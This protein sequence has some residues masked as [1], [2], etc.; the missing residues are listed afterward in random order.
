MPVPRRFRA[1]ATGTAGKI[2]W[3]DRLRQR[4]NDIVPF[5]F[6]SRLVQVVNRSSDVEE[7]LDTHI[8]VRTTHTQKI[9]LGAPFVCRVRKVA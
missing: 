1:A 7:F 8:P 9:M 4:G 5:V 3:S 6:F 2:K